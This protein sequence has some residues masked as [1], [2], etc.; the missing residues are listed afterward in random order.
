MGEEMGQN[1]NQMI[2]VSITKKRQICIVGT[3]HYDGAFL[4][5]MGHMGLIPEGIAEKFKLKDSLKNSGKAEG[6]PPG[7]RRLQRVVKTKKNTQAL[8]ESFTEQI[9]VITV[10][11]GGT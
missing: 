8:T 5:Q 1:L 3:T 10:V 4:S 7:E 11:V 2:N 6:L 9:L